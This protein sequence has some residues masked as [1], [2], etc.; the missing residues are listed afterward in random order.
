MSATYLAEGAQALQPLS[1][2]L[3]WAA[4]PGQRKRTEP[5]RTCDIALLHS[6]D[7][8]GG[9]LRCVV[10]LILLM[11]VNLESSHKPIVIRQSWQAAAAILTMC[12]LLNQLKNRYVANHI[13]KS[14]I[15]RQFPSK[16]RVGVVVQGGGGGVSYMG[17]IKM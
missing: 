6:T 4:Q 7:W 10:E 2:V 15:H 1:E 9:D 8:G 17:C 14:P 5:C 11:V 12:S 13:P 16:P 3:H